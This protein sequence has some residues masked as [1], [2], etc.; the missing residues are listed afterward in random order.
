[1]KGTKKWIQ[2]IKYVSIYIM[3]IHTYMHTHTRACAHRIGLLLLIGPFFKTSI[4]Y[5][6]ITDESKE[7]KC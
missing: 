5:A 4:V 3:Y 2:K 7:G 1:M 6:N